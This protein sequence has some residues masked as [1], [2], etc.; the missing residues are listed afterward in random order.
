MK[1]KD[2]AL[3]QR[4]SSLFYENQSLCGYPIRVLAQDG[5][6]YLS[7]RVDSSQRRLEAEH[8]ASSTVG[9]RRVVNDI[10]YDDEAEP[11]IE[12]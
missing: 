7:G 5:T 2:A 9:V 1:M 12:G 4:V 11:T 6:V 8:I 10:S 3:A